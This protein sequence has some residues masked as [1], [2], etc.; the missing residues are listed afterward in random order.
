MRLIQIGIIALILLIALA[1]D[2][3][4]R[5]LTRAL[6]QLVPALSNWARGDFNS[7]VRIATRIR[8]ID[9]IRPR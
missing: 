7:E 6:G 1:I 4:Q 3:L 2:R 5:Q 9:D 8:E